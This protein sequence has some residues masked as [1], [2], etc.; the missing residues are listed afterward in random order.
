MSDGKQTVQSATVRLAVEIGLRHALVEAK[1]MSAEELAVKSGADKLLVK[2]PEYY[3]SASFIPSEK[4]AIEYATGSNFWTFLNERP[5]LHQ[6]FLV[7]MR[8]RKDGNPRWL[9]YFP[10]STQVDDLSTAEDAVTLVDIGGNL[11]HDVKL[12]Q[13][14]CPDIPGRVVLMD[15][16][17]V[18]R[19]NP[20]PLI[21]IE[22]VGYDFF[23]PQP[24][25]ACLK[26]LSN[27]VKAMKPGYSRLLINEQALPNV[28]AELHPTML[29][30]TMMTNFNAM[31]RTERHWRTLLGRLGV[32]IVK[33]WRIER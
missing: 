2:L 1:E 29:D 33:I 17:E 28:G 19:G 11:G 9:D 3:H 18:V 27:T 5:S 22:K 20:D 23:T 32:E 15:L 10:V 24:V 30:L 8:G 12:F 4:T 7:Y 6:D 16:P 31:E 26:F 21:G 13:E 25:I 14:R